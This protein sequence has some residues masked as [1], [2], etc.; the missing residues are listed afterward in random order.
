MLSTRDVPYILELCSLM[1]VRSSVSL[2]IHLSTFSLVFLSTQDIRIS[3]MQLREL[4]ERVSSGEE[5]LHG[6]K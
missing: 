6:G 5:C 3:E 1:I 2:S 4:Q